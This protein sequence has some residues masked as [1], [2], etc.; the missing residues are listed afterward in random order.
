MNV[1]ESYS[2]ALEQGT[3]SLSL[4]ERLSDG[5]IS[6]DYAKKASPQKRATVTDLT[7]KRDGGHRSCAEKRVA[8]EGVLV[9]HEI[10]LLAQKRLKTMYSL[11]RLMLKHVLC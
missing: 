8:P 7:S 10:M 1:R 6:I 4:S 9:T 3:L 11:H 2:C 5:S